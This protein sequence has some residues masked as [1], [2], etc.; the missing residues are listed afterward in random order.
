MLI[1]FWYEILE[2]IKR[3][4]VQAL[5]TGVGI[6]WGI[7]IL[8]VLVGI[9][10]GFERGV[11][12]LF[13][14]FSKSTTYIYSSNTTIPY[15]GTPSGKR[16]VFTENDLAM[17]RQSVP[18]IDKIS[19]EVGQWNM[20]FS[21]EKKGWF[22]TKGV[23]PE[24]FDIKLLEIKQGR[25]LNQSD[26]TENRNV[27]LIGE[28]VAEVLFDHRDP[29]GKMI[30][31]G[32]ELYRVVGIIKNTLLNTMEARV[33]Y[34]PYSV[35]LL[36]ANKGDSKFTTALF[37]LQGKNNQQQIQS[38]IRSLMA[39]KYNF[40]PSDEKVFY[41]NSMEEQ[42]KA[43]KDLFLMLR[44]FLW[45]MGISTLVGG[46]IGVANI[47]YASARERTRE[48]GI[49]KSVGARNSDVK[50]MIIWESIVLTCSTGCLGI[51]SG[52]IFLE[53]VG[54]FISDDM[55]MDYPK[56]DISTSIAA[57]FILVIAGTLAG[58]K[59]ALYAAELNPID[60]LGNEN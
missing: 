59:P 51:I 27:V 49:R 58:L 9:G 43:F 15:K 4:P 47:M 24:Y 17:L 1:D 60:A 31:I 19:P 23:Y 37:S 11:L 6:T 14:G 16:V 30:R 48:I 28:N 2:S 34:M 56:V 13:S 50:S 22:E 38:R 40:S 5:L 32:N 39:H 55:M 8:I 44:K 10:S 20:A 21:G 52:W 57:L 18:Q 35:W 7:F 41:Y 29:I 33:I 42:V 54:L 3:K 36:Q 26:A 46:V 25:L 53:I 12:K 45:F